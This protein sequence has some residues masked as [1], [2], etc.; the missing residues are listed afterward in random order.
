VL[1][2]QL[3]ELC[4]FNE[5]E[6][7]VGIIAIPKTEEINEVFATVTFDSVEKAALFFR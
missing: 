3:H 4:N 1:K 6:Y 2:K 7:N 5:A